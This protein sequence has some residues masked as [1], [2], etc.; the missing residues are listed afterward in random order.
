MKKNAVN[1]ENIAQIGIRGFWYSKFYQDFVKKTGI[2]C[3][4]P[5]DVERDGIDS[6]LASS[7]EAAA[8]G[9]DAIYVSVDIDSLDPAFAPGTDGPTPGGL[10][11]LSVFRAIYE[12][13]QHPLVRA[14]DVMEVSPPLDIDN[15]T[16]K[17][18]AEI[19]MRFL[20]GHLKYLSAK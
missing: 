15:R 11:V 19:F 18:A 10:S 2:T 13:G 6:V 16:S 4:S 5:I 7:I 12:L 3:F 8:D 17:V 1:G 9:T 20:C 14:L